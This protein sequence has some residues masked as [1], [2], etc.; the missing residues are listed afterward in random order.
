[1]CSR[2]KK[3]NGE[4][5]T[6]QQELKCK[7]CSIVMAIA[8]ETEGDLLTLT[9][10]CLCGKDNKFTFLGYPKLFGTHEVYFEF[11]DEQEI[12]CHKRT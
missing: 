10:K 3:F 12:T 7:N 4:N 6:V 9:V 2:P 11:T 1:M 5:L 8:K